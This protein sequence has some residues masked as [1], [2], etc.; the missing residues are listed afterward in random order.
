MKFS[1]NLEL[2]LSYV[3]YKLRK[4]KEHVIVHAIII[5]IIPSNMR[6]HRRPYGPCSLWYRWALDDKTSKQVKLQTSGWFF[7]RCYLKHRAFRLTRV[8][9]I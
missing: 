9:Q 8:V 5:I 4:P 7:Q 2:K 1:E 6:T 3:V